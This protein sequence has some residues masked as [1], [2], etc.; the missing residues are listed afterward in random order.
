MGRGDLAAGRPRV[1]AGGGFNGAAP[2]GARRSHHVLAAEWQSVLL[3]RGRA[4][5]GAEI[6]PSRCHAVPDSRLQRGRAFWGA[7]I[8]ALP[9]CKVSV[10][11]AS[12]GPRL[13]G[14]G[15]PNRSK[16]LVRIWIRFN[17]AAPFGARRCGRTSSSSTKAASFNGAAP[18]GARRYSTCGTKKAWSSSASTGPRLLGRGDASHSRKT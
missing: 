18:F 11:F 9:R 8:H 4:F 10:R 1:G 17:G 13:L 16:F 15:D 3:Q 14:R 2:F 6:D 5:W 7:E 12:T